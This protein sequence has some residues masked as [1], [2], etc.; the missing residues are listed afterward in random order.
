MWK[1]ERKKTISKMPKGRNGFNSE[2]D[3]NI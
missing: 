1:K 2:L 3:Y